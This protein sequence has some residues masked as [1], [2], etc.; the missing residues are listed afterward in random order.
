LVIPIVLVI[1]AFVFIAYTRR[2]ISKLTLVRLIV[3]ILA[4][5]RSS[6]GVVTYIVFIYRFTT[7]VI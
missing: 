1:I 3:L 5:S 7:C 2:R 6:Y 4:D